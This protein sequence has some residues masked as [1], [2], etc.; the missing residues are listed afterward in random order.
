VTL[1]QFLEEA[2][3]DLEDVYANG[4]TWTGLR[5][6]A[7]VDARSPTAIDE[8][9]ERALSRVLH[10][11]DPLRLDGIRALVRQADAPRADADDALQRLLF[12]LLGWPRQP[13]TELDAAWSA[14]WANAALRSEL[15]QLLTLLGDRVRHVTRPVPGLPLQVHATYSLDEVLAGVDERNVK[16][17][18]KRIQTGVF[19][20]ET[21]GADLLFV[22][23]EKSETEYSPTT[24]YQD[25]AISPRRFHWE[26]QSNCHADTETGRRHIATARGG[27]RALLFV[28]QRRTDPRG[29]TMPYV[30]LGDVYCAAWR[31]GRP[32]QIEWE[33]EHEMPARLFQETKLAAG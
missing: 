24:L 21:A 11:D 13:Y 9:M 12:I 6:A 15:D 22:T 7:G 4:R 19:H 17:G 26:S 14:L 3:V 33:L 16:G 1:A 5:R 27:N 30:F 23:L 20:S 28:R 25:Y 10:L 18:V 2:G 32:M 29:E 8:R 31:G